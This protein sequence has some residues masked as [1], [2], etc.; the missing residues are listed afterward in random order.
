M[1]KVSLGALWVLFVWLVFKSGMNTF[2]TTKKK[3]VKN[4]LK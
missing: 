1:I 4:M 3:E 2:G